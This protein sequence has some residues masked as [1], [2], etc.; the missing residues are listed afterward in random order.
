[1]S[2]QLSMFGDSADSK[3]DASDVL[4]ETVETPSTNLQQ[5]A[6][7]EA[8]EYEALDK[9]LAE[10]MQELNSS[11]DKESDL[12]IAQNKVIKRCTLEI[13]KHT[14]EGQIAIPVTEEDQAV[15]LQTNV[16]G[17]A[18]DYKPLIIDQG[19]LY[20]RRYWQYQNQLAKQIRARMTVDEDIDSITKSENQD[21]WAQQRLD[22]LFSDDKD[23]ANEKES[24]EINW[25]RRAVELA[26][27]HQFLIVSGGPGT[28]KT[29][30]IT[31]LLA[32]LIEQHLSSSDEK[33]APKVGG[34]LTNNFKVLL[35]APTG[36][37]AIRMLDSIRDAQAG[38][39]LT[40]DAAA[41]MPS[42]ASTIHKLLGYQHGSVNFKHNRNNSLNADVVLVDEASMI[43]IALMSKL[44]EAVPAHAKL[45]LIGDKDQLSS[46]ETGSVFADMCSGLEEDKSEH[47]VTL[48]KN[49]RFSKDSDIGQSAIAANQGDSRKLL[50]LLKD[51]NS[52]NCKLI[53][54]D[55]LR[56]AELIKPWRTY[57]DVINNPDASYDEIFQA[58]T[59]YRVLC[60][61]RRGPNGSVNMSSRIETA[62]AKQNQIHFRK[63]FSN[64]N[65]SWYHG[66]PIMITQNS[67][68]KGLFNGDTGITLIRDGE[69][70]V[71]FPSADD[72][73]SAAD[74]SH[75][76]KSFSPVRLPAH[77]TTWAMTIHKSQG[78][79]FNQVVLILPHEE[80]PLLTR[81][82][83]YTGITRAKEQVSIVAS[84]SV[85]VTGVKAEVVKA[86]RIEQSLSN[87]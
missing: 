22:E 58:F 35:A 28:G 15:L 31:R 78:S 41:L 49:W 3:K 7:P 54:P 24:K 84:E 18:G 51:S 38:L 19:Y 60:A 17:E 20:L 26:L 46:V 10:L 87:A 47:L 36:K 77:E 73:L 4:P 72:G 23:S 59:Q 11:K 45:I 42:E 75:A 50:S 79:E 40:E 85:L 66:R 34:G 57:I 8:E 81:Q 67:Y 6:P 83:I 55:T 29:T 63:K 25:Q 30:T 32:L 44:V 65:Q 69:V 2:E 82:L 74:G 64:N 48:K 37:A 5:Q 70:K 13:S 61:L 14:R 62:L 80:M 21:S 76:Y 16:G 56:D 68:G 52:E 43:D 39:G 33:T 86:T 9:Q 53:A 27:K 12:Q 71:Y 1:M